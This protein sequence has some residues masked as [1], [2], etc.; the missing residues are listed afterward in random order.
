MAAGLL[1]VPQIGVKVP[2]CNFEPLDVLQLLHGAPQLA[3]LGHA[4]WGDATPLADL[5]AADRSRNIATC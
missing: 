2:V 5:A 3:L 4:K 1:A